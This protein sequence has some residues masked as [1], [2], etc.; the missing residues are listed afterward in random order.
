MCSPAATELEVIVM[1][2]LGKFLNLPE[3]FLPSGKG[4]GGG[5]IQGSASESIL[6]AVLAAREEKV[7][8]MKIKRPDLSES[9]VRSKLVGYGSIHSNSAIEKSGLLSATKIR[10][11]DAD[12]TSIL[13]GETVQKA[14]E[15]DIAN[16]LIPFVCITTIGTTGTCAFDN[17]EEIG[18]ILKK[19]NVWM[20][21]DAA[22]A[23]AA[24]CLPEYAHI[25]KG[26]EYG[27]SINFNL[28]KW[29]LVN[30]DCAAMW[31]KDAAKLT[32]SFNV[33]RIY[34]D[35]K[36]QGESK[37]P[38]YRHW[39]LALGRRFRSLRVWITFRTY[40]QEYIRNYLRKH[41]NLAGMF[42]NYVNKDDRFEETG[43]SLALAYF[44]L[45]GDDSLT[46]KLLDRI[47]T[48]RNIYL[49]PAFYHN[50]V[51]IRFVI[52]GLDPQEKDIDYAWNEVKTVTDEL[53]AEMEAEKNKI[54]AINEIEAEIENLEIT[55]K[56]NVITENFAKSITLCE[57][58]TVH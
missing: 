41:I 34:L 43:Q 24:F 10:L 2:W 15:D 9:D 7:R 55:D 17:M 46:R 45:K 35:H 40:G 56:V 20:H 54:P 18:P 26:A 52:C 1:D 30:F 12:D 42:L 33:E 25:K 28:H 50:K 11:L 51:I 4:N 3:H 38:D 47:N 32:K 48:R 29:M 44:R 36:Y 49:I 13:R 6:V 21:I 19:Y 37:A 22:Y 8:E 5:I 27:D 58:K 53:L 57:E 31:I 39:Q 23:G 14:I 16:G